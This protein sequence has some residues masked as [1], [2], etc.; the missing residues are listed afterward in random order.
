MDGP[1]GPGRDVWWTEAIKGTRGAGA[2]GSKSFLR[3]F[4]QKS[5]TYLQM[6]ALL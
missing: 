5:A 2:R 3:A 1:V 6:R 4:F